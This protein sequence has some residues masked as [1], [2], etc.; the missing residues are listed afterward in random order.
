[1]SKLSFEYQLLFVKSVNECVICMKLARLIP[2]KR[3]FVKWHM[4]TS[5]NE[6]FEPLSDSHIYG[7][8]LIQYFKKAS[9]PMT[10]I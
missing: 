1:M 9:M 7:C 5:V 6:W 3:L 8:A 10:K 2:N 4:V